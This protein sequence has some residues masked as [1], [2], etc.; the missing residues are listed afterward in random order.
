MFKTKEELRA[1][2][3]RRFVVRKKI[4]WSYVEKVLLVSPSLTQKNGFV[5]PIG[6]RSRLI[7]EILIFTLL[8]CDFWAEARRATKRPSV[9]QPQNR[10][11]A[12]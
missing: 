11:R 12:L 8:L 9:T 4:V 3:A 6:E 5:H 7:W 10:A 1:P 2:S